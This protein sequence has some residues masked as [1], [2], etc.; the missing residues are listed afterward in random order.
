MMGR[1]KAVKPEKAFLILGIIFG[2]AFLLITPPFQV[3]DESTH[4]YKS[5]YLSDGHIL[6]EKQGDETG[7]YVTKSAIETVG[8]F[9]SLPFHPENKI[10]MDYT[11]SLV[12]LPLLNSNKTFVDCSLFAIVSYPPFPY[13]ASASVIF[14][15]KLFNFSPLVLFYLG[16]IVNLLLYVLIIYMAIRLMP[17]HKWVLLLLTL[18]PMTI[19]EAASF[20]VDS[21]TIA[22]S[23]L[24]IAL[25]F[26][27]T[28]ND[29]KKELSNKDISVIGILFL[30]LALSKQ[31]YALLIFLFFMLPASKV[32]GCKKKFFKFV[33]IFLPIVLVVAFWSF[34]I[35]G[36]YTPVGAKSQLSFLLSSPLAFPKILV[37]T[38][39]INTNSYIFMF[40]GSL[41]GWL[42]TP[43]PD[44]LI[45]FYLIILILTA[46]LDKNEIKINLKQKIVPLIIFIAISV[47]IFFLEYLTW[48]SVGNNKIN[49]VQGRY[50][51]PIAPLL[52][53]SLYNNKLRISNKWRWNWLVILAVVLALL[54]TLFILV[55]RYYIT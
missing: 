38:L 51:I 43:L 2:I 53:L 41:L 7:F 32:G 42:D 33:Y 26:N 31:V 6:P 21:F 14:L 52:F 25:L 24:T 20:S 46:L 15:G 8:A 34:L 5:L 49:G 48:T 47:S 23:F 37:N 36:L 39:F 54:V 1:L 10:K 12:N 22:V 40:A 11:P 4:F 44:W 30:I 28:F 13:L 9:Q 35:K 45:Y 50:F 55:K 19:F 16:R 29:G 3:A 18:M 17:V 27:F